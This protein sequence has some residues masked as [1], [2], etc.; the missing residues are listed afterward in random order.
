MVS[1]TR[2][3][4]LVVLACSLLLGCSA[5][6]QE[7]AEWTIDGP[8]PSAG[9]TRFTIRTTTPGVASGCSRVFDPILQESADAVS[10]VVPV[11]RASSSAE[12]TD[13]LRVGTYTIN[14]QEPLGDRE[15]LGCGRPTCG[16][17]AP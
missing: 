10:V 16:G 7:H 17:A 11:T 13:D 8:R 12:C 3:G 4:I 6:T 15:L 14:L 1:V 5:T 9:T 2:G